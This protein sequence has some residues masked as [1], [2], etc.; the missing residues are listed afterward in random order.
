MVEL[1]LSSCCSCHYPFEPSVC[2]SQQS[3][4]SECVER[5]F[6]NEVRFKLSYHLPDSCEGRPNLGIHFRAQNKAI[7]MIPSS[8]V[9]LQGPRCQ[10]LSFL[11]VG[12]NLLE[13]CL[14]HSRTTG[15]WCVRSVRA[16]FGACSWFQT[17]IVGEKLQTSVVCPEPWKDGSNNSVT[18]AAG[19][20]TQ[21]D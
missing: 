20:Q 17:S 3:T 8:F 12:V 7:S 10:P 15:E 4:R 14:Y 18:G 19:E 16:Q 1:Q 9:L 21:C 5:M 13:F 6:A 2:I 11:G